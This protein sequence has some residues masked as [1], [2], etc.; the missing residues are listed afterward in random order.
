MACQEL[1]ATHQRTHLWV[2]GKPRLLQSL[3]IVQTL[4]RLVN[5]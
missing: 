4:L 2:Q 5:C 3:K 1:C